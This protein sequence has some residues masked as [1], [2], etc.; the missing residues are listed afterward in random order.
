MRAL[1]SWP[2]VFAGLYA[3]HPQEAPL[4]RSPVDACRIVSFAAGVLVAL[5]GTSLEAAAQD[6]E[7]S[8][9]A[10]PPTLD[11]QAPATSWERGVTLPLS[12][13]VVHNRP[14]GEATSV[15]VLSDGRFLYVRFD[16]T[17]RE[18]MVVTQHSND[19]VTGGSQSS[20]NG[21][22]AWGNDDAVWVDLWP[23]GPTGFQYQFEANPIGAHNESSSENAAFA[24][25]WASRGAV[26]DDGYTVTM[27]IPLDVIHRAHSG[28]WR[29]QF[30]RYVRAT[31]AQD[32]WSFDA[33]Q[34]NV[35][36]PAR[37]GPLA[38]TFT[39]T[40]APLPKPRVG[41]YALGS[42]ASAQAGGSTSR[43]GA[44]LSVPVTPTSAFFAA[45]HPDYSNVELDQQTIAPS[46]YPRPFNEVRPFFTQAAA[47]YN[48]F[49]CD[50]CL[51]NREI[52]YTPAIPT[53]AQGYGFE[54]KAGDLGFAGFDAIGDGRTDAAGTVDYNSTDT[55]WSAE[56]EHVTADLPGL[57]DD[58]N[59][60]GAKWSNLKYL[61]AYATFSNDTGTNVPN[62]GQGTAAD[63]GGGFSSSNLA[64]F[65][66][67]RSVGP[68]FDPVDGYVAHPGIAGYA[69]YGARIW[70]FAPSSPFAAAGVTA[71]TDLY[72]GPTFGTSQSDNEM[73][74]DLLTRRTWDFQVYSGSDYWRF[75]PT[76]EPVSQNAGFNIVYH[77]AMQTNNPS[78][79]L[80]H[81][82]AAT[83]TEIQYETGRYGVGRLDTWFRTST[84]RVGDKGTVTFTAND[85]AQ[86]MPSGPNNIQWFEGVAYAYQ[87]DRASS[88]A[89][90]IRRINGLPPQPNGGGDCSGTCANVSIAYHLRLAN[91]ELYLAYGNPNT[92][93]TVPQALLK[94]IFYLGG[95][96]GT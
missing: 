18:P 36:D 30:I 56:V 57:V 14:A 64:L 53:F 68:S 74:F 52:L 11:P 27:A 51:A 7:P 54:G 77:S 32:V 12:W 45:L 84:V 61:S 70:E 9:A 22:L 87:I 26:R 82:T 17:Q 44:D 92:L 55:R 79:F 38:V 49:P 95:Q 13:D 21:S 43:V 5:A 73:L 80:N 24:P 47:Y 86:W 15:R 72:H 41:V 40:D 83:P 75:G 90:G 89:L 78:N 60:I 25:Q 37:A 71:V 50:V 69:L 6:A 66:G 85:T 48:N 16:A 1:D 4:V 35:D 93:T 65:G 28:T 39:G 62:P 91:E 46:V 59:E 29:A 23:T 81:G 63:L 10:T 94:L 42:A 20:T 67:I 3:A 33:A 58:A 8:G 88:F 19:T 76:L 2:R 34:T 96:K 31:G